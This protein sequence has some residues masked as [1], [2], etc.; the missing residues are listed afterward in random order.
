[1]GARMSVRARLT[2]V[3]PRPIR[4]AAK[5]GLQTLYMKPTSGL[6]LLPEFLIIGAQRCGTTSLYRYLAEH[7][8][9]GPVV[10]TKGAHYFSTNYDKSFEWYRSHFP[11]RLHQAY[12]KRR[13]GFDMITGEGSPY[14]VFHPLAPR[15]VAEK[16][17][18]VKLILMLRDPVKRA[19]SHY[20]HMLDRGLEHLTL[21]EAL[22]AE[23]G[24]LA[25][26]RERILSDPSYYSFDHQHHSYL[27]RGRYLE[28][29][30]VWHRFFPREQML[31][32]RSEDFFSAT[33]TTYGNVLEFLALPPWDLPRFE[34]HNAGHYSDMNPETRRWLTDYFAEPNRELASYLGI[35]LGWST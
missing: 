26:Q 11:T 34:A 22:Q 28:Q 1:M 29:I 31:V 2:R 7:P 19:Y 15:R 3:M 35:D 10:L 12:V 16:L 32:I 25:G 30:D 9:V 13:F 20:R 17:P 5:H 4:K 8:A 18:D 14:Y 23:P 6:R 24:R 33:A 27:A 21:E